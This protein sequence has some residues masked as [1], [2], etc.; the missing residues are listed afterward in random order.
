MNKYVIDE[1]RNGREK[2]SKSVREG[3]GERRERGR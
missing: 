1:G 3:E 2:R